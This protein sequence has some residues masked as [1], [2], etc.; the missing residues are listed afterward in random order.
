MLMVKREQHPVNS[1]NISHEIQYIGIRSL[2]S[3]AILFL[4]DCQSYG[5]LKGTGIERWPC[6]LFKNSERGI[7]QDAGGK[8]ADQ[9]RSPGGNG[10]GQKAGDGTARLLAFLEVRKG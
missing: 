2:Q 7:H 4:L 9:R 6:W 3:M 1:F 5:S 8:L 10:Q